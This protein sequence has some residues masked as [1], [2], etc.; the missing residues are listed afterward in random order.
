MKE[1]ITNV[2]NALNIALLDG[3]YSSEEIISIIR[4]NSQLKEVFT[5][6]Q[7]SREPLKEIMF[8]GKDILLG[9]SGNVLLELI[10][11]KIDNP[12][13][14]SHITVLKILETMTWVWMVN[15]SKA[16]EIESLITFFE[17][18][19]YMRITPAV[20]QRVKKCVTGYEDF[21]ID[22]Y[23]GDETV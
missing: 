9:Q 6:D 11:K 3:L 16:D 21:D 12:Y 7:L 20:M 15:N 1:R 14:Q 22:T 23:L 19:Q 13:F 2:I 5:E 18:E 8:A 17:E 4:N 10:R